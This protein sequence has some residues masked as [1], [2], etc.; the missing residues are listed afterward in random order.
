MTILATCCLWIVTDVAYGVRMWELNMA[1]WIDRILAL[2]TLLIATVIVY[3]F[4]NYLANF[5]FDRNKDNKTREKITEYIWMLA[6]TAIIFNISLYIIIHFINATNYRWGEA[7]LINAAALPIFLLYYTSI[8]NGIL[9]E[10]YN[11]K[12]IQLEKLKVDQLKTELKLLRGQYH[13]HFLFNALN[14]VYFQID[15]EN[16]AAIESVELLSSL[17]RYQLYDINTKVAI[18]QEIDYLRT[19]IKFQQLRMPDRMQF[20]HSFDPNLGEQKIHPLLFQPLMENAFKYVGGNYRIQV[21]MKKEDSKVRFIVKNTLNST[22]TE[23][24]KGTGIG[25]DNLKRRL[26]LLYPNKHKLQIMDNNTHFTVDL[27]I[28]LSE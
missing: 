27:L 14:T 19:Y 18:R 1:A 23:I 22:L 15:E 20:E 26:N 3:L 11:E 12:L 8:R 17:L 7:F 6:F 4:F 21:Q 10:H 16:E 25:I 13:P 5:F 9:M 24:K 28:D 2:S